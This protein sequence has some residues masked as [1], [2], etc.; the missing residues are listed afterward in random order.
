MQKMKARRIIFRIVI[1]VIIGVVLGSVVYS[2]NAKRVMHDEMPMPLGFGM[3]VV[4]TGSME[5]TLK[6]NELVFIVKANEYSVGDIIVYQKENQ[7][8][9]HRIIQLSGDQVVTQ[10]DHNNTADEPFSIKDVKGKLKFSIPY[11]G[12]IVRGIRSLP[13][14]IL[15]LALAFFLMWL[16]WQSEKQAGDSE[17]EELKEQIRKL[18]SELEADGNAMGGSGAD[19]GSE[20]VAD[21]V[22]A[23][24]PVEA[25]GEPVGIEP[26]KSD[27]ALET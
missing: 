7:L 9:I 23:A 3:S 21:N 2:I 26:A 13:G 27:E 5:P 18:K 14:V 1:I 20:S 17:L 15:I 16:S 6:V 22:P 12:I 11:V 24:D 4:L 25:E 19:N 8:I 10:G